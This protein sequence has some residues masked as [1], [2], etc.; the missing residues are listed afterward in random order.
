ML[1]IVL[2][3]II[4]FILH[5]FWIC[6]LNK[7]RVYFT[8]FQGH[9]FSCNPKYLYQYLL[10]HNKKGYSFVWEF[11]DL[12]KS[13][14]VPD[15]ITVKAKSLKSIIL[16]LTSKYIITNAEFH[17]Y[18]P[19]RKSQVLLETWHGGGAYKKVGVDAGWNKALNLEQKLN[20]KQISFYVSS[21]KKFTE[22]QSSSKCVAVEKFINTGMPRNSFLITEEK[23]KRESIFK[24]LPISDSDKIVLYAP[25]YRGAAKYNSEQEKS[26]EEL[27]YKLL[28]DSL[29]KKFGGD[30]L[31]LYRGHYYSK[32][33]SLESDSKVINV[34]DYDD[35]QELLYISD[36]LITDYSSCMWD[37]SLMNKP[38]FLYANDIDS[39]NTERGFYTNPYS[40]PFSI[41]KNNQDLDKNISNFNSNEYIEKVKLH[42]N[43]FG[44]YECEDAAKKIYDAMGIETE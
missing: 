13:N 2:K 11:L 7:K 33:N 31:I 8:A 14:L 37:F 24:K 4:W 20:S 19:L 1:K 28:T 29:E 43:E 44:S 40:W 35:M 32:G 16:C 25:T 15:S 3:S 17:W 6:P 18:I 30:W 27:N 26:Y 36:V 39:Y 41:S 22:V 23:D 42:H 5:I 38:V 34:T 9:Q 10:T 21:S 12:S